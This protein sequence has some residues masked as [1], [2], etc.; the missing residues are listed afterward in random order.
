MALSTQN[1]STRP[2]AVYLILL[3]IVLLLMVG[4]Y[5]IWAATDNAG[6]NVLATDPQSTSPPAP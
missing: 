4:A 5:A 6:T 3:G 2:L 1:P